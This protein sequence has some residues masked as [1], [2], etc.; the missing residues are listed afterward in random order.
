MPL[1]GILGF[2]FLS[3]FVIAIDY[4]HKQLTLY[5]CAHDT[6]G[7]RG[8]V[9]LIMQGEQPYLDGSIVVGG[10]TIPCWFILDV[11]AADTITFTT[12]FI[13][14]HQ[15]LDRAGDKARVVQ[16]VA[17]PDVEAFAPTNVRGLIDAVKLGEITLPHVPVNLSVSKKGAYT[18]P[19]FDGNIGE[20]ILS[21]FPRVVLD[22]GRSVMFLEPGPETTKPMEERKTFGMTLIASGDDFTTFTVTAVGAASPAARAGFQK[23]DVIAAVDGKPASRFNLALVKAIL[24]DDGSKH[25]FAVK[26]K[27]EQVEL[28]ATIERVPLSGLK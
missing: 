19:A 23:G 21:R 1:G 8:A 27:S 10:E 25:V 5:D 28:P 16:H 17:A 13:A 11:G 3:R 14:A 22:Y 7:E 26:R 20:T 9:R 24:A 18:S 15:L 4:T 6:S 12:P 2:D